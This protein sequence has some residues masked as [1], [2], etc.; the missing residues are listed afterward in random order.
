[1]IWLPERLWR[2]S[3]VCPTDIRGPLQMTMASADSVLISER[4][5]ISLLRLKEDPP[6][7]YQPFFL[8]W[9]VSATPKAPFHGIHHPN[10]GIKKVAVENEPLT[11][12]SFTGIKY[13]MEPNAHWT[14]RAWDIG[15]T[16]KGSSGS[17]LLNKEK[18]IVGTLTGGISECT[19]PRGP[20]QYASLSKFWNVQGSIDNPNSIQFY[21]D[22]ASTKSTR[23]DSYQPHANSPYTR[24]MNFST[25][26][27]PIETLHQSVPMFATNNAFGYSE[28]AEEFFAESKVQIEGVFIS[29]P[30]NRNMPNNDIRIRIYSGDEK[31]DQLIHEQE[32]SYSYRYHSSNGIL[33]AQRDM[34]HSVEN[35][36]AF[37]KPITLTGNF[38]ISYSEVNGT[39]NGFTVFNTEPR[40]IGS[41]KTATAWI[42]H[43][44][45]W[46]RS[47]ENIENPINTSLLIAP[48]MVGKTDVAVPTT[49]VE[50]S[51]TIY[52]EREVN[53]IFIESNHELLE[54]EIFYVSGQKIHAGRAEKSINRA[55]FPMTHFAKGV[56][57]VKVKTVGG[58]KAVKKV[59][60]M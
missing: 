8:G 13:N 41:G 42:K 25:E 40:A 48:Y 3:P 19:S 57:I 23:T 21:L 32:Y 52:Y 28:F 49:N 10:G 43:N 30:A 51:I 29:S 14:V 27:T 47:S 1:M 9:D 38:Y 5:D 59:L 6:A 4:H 34:R 39:P 16:E 53:R 55:S 24:S 22:P 20:D 46:I 2:F 45:E 60:I 31:P 11:I 18:Q 26:E 17:P 50:A 35:Y 15:T 54:W 33:Y 37:D 56:Y 36:I 44:N 12:T 58:A 7:Y